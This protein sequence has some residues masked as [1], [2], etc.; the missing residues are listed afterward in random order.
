M[1]GG[2]NWRK[3]QE[4]PLVARLPLNTSG[5]DPMLHIPLLRWVEQPQGWCMVLSDHISGEMAAQQFL[6]FR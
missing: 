6:S 2:E 5:E 1:F 3:E 4:P